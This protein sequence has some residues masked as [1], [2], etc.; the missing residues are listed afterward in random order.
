M[1]ADGAKFEEDAMKCVED[2]VPMVTANACLTLG[3]MAEISSPNSASA[4]KVADCLKDKLPMVR[5]AALQGL[6]KMG[7]E[8]TNYLE[9]VVKRLADPV[10]SVKTAACTAIGGCG[11][12]GQMYAADVC[13]L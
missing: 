3:A 5:A 9:E 11:E 2:P 7:D 6:A 8:A 4:E 10:W 1:G 12:M 13:R